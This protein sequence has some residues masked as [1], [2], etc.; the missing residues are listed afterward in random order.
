MEKSKIILLPLIIFFIVLDGCGSR[1]IT[2]IQI[3]DSDVPILEKAMS[4]LRPIFDSLGTRIGSNK[5]V[6][7]RGFE[8]DSLKD[9]LRISQNDYYALSTLTIDNPYFSFLDSLSLEQFK[10]DIR[11]LAKNGMTRGGVQCEA[12]CIY[13]YGYIS[14]FDDDYYTTKSI[15]YADSTAITFVDDNGNTKKTVN[16]AIEC[17]RKKYDIDDIKGKIWMISNKLE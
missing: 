12:C 4:N 9:V 15:F 17:V 8:Y 14:S 3:R 16:S 11:L 1:T 5:D 2:K 7:P 10:N 13:L 6:V